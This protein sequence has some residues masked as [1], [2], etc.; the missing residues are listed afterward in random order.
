VKKKQMADFSLDTSLLTNFE[1][2]LFVNE[3]K[4]LAKDVQI[5]LKKKECV[6]FFFNDLKQDVCSIRSL[7]AIVRSGIDILRATIESEMATLARSGK[8]SAAATEK[9]HRYS[10]MFDNLIPKINSILQPSKAAPARKKVERKKKLKFK[11]EYLAVDDDEEDEQGNSN[12]PR[13][14]PLLQKISDVRREEQK[15]E[16]IAEDL[17]D[18]EEEDE[19]E[20]ESQDT[21]SLKEFIVEDEKQKRDDDDE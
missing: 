15:H 11:P 2:V 20:N 3:V 7:L 10:R 8:R 19:F 4:R 17:K 6:S 13:K 12:H 5:V 18:Y 14:R 9:Y 1:P 16:Q 21:G